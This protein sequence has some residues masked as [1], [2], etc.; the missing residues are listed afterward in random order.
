MKLNCFGQTIQ[1]TYIVRSC[2]YLKDDGNIDWSQLK[3]ADDDGFDTTRLTY[4]CY[5]IPYII[6]K[7]T[8]IIRYGHPKGNFTAPYGTKYEEISLPYDIASMEYHEYIVKKNCRVNCVVKKGYAAPGFGVMGGGIQYKHKE[9][10]LELLYKGILKEDY[11][12]S[13]KT[14]SKKLLKI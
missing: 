7:G 3:D 10:I 13:I 6:P 12:W 5:I 2:D 9:S 11:K 14:I 8:K 1:K 4:C